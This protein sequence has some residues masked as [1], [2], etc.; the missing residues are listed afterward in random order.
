MFAFDAETDPIEVVIE[1]AWAW[2]DVAGAK[3]SLCNWNCPTR[4]GEYCLDCHATAA[5][6]AGVGRRRM[7]A[8]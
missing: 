4:S 6:A 2:T 5:N 1:L 8:A 7:E 3:Q